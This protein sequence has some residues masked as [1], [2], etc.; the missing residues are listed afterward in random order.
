[1]KATEARKKR[2]WRSYY[3]VEQKSLHVKMY[4][5]VLEQLDK[6][7]ATDGTPRNQLINQ[8]CE[9]YCK[10]LDDERREAAS[11]KALQCTPSAN[12]TGWVQAELTAGRYEQ[13]EFIARSLGCDVDRAAELLLERAVNDYNG[14]PFA[15]M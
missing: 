7:S 15:Y 9:Y 12:R 3:G 10:Q 6:E 4:F 11:G 1:M 8:A 13:L 2:R 5:D 14:R